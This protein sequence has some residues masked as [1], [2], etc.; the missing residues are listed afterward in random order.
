MQLAAYSP[1][2]EEGCS[3]AEGTQLQQTCCCSS[4]QYEVSL[5]LLPT[6]EVWKHSFQ[7]TSSS[8]TS[9]GFLT[10]AAQRSQGQGSFKQPQ[11]EGSSP[12][13]IPI[14]AR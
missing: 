7:E 8:C 10:Q 1:Q 14:S 2:W 13:S 9:P 12:P 6:P 5:A 11:Q 4:S 3:K